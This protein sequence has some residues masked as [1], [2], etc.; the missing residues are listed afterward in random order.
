MARIRSEYVA[1]MEMR[2]A[3]RAP[4]VRFLHVS[5]RI[6]ERKRERRAR[7]LYFAAVAAVTAGLFITATN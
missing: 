2:A 1:N 5:K 3:A 7:V 6:R 4:A